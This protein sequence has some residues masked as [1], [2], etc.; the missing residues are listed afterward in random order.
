[1]KFTNCLWAAV[2]ATTL[3]AVA[4]V[5]TVQANNELGVLKC[6]T[7]ADSRKN[8]L[9]RST[10]DVNCVFEKKGGGFEKYIGETGIAI[11][12]SLTFKQSS[13]KLYYAVAANT[14]SLA[15]GALAGK[16]IGGQA[17]VAVKKG[18]GGAVLVGGGNDQISLSP[19]GLTQEGYGASAGVG[20]LHLQPVE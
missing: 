15:A 17:D 20:F 14:T 8:Y 11:G 6:E 10:A 18:A 4:P 9:I 7:V 2:G 19:M 3:I 13:E 16:F 12:V 5:A 1:M